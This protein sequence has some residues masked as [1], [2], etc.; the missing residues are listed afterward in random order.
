MEKIPFDSVKDALQRKGVP[1]VCPM[2]GKPELKGL[3]KEEFQLISMNHPKD[4]SIDPSETTMLPC[5]TVICLNCGHVAQF[6][7]EWLLK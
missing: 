2:C 4:G 5:A 7:L 1:H 6:A 3:R